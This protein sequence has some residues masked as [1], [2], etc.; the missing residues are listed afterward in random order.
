[1]APQHLET[2]HMET[3]QQTKTCTKCGEEKELTQFYKQKRGK[4]G[5]RP[6]CID[7]HKEYNKKYNKEYN[8]KN[9]EKIKLKTQRWRKANPEKVKEISRKCYYKNPERYKIKAQRWRKANPEKVKESKRK[10]Y[11]EHPEIRK[12]RS[13]KL[14]LMMSDSYIKQRIRNQFSIFEISTNDITPEWINIK[15]RIIQTKR[16]K[17][18]IKTQLS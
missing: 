3:L 14:T 5:V 18:N 16:I 8:V 10:R 4:Y 2:K 7:C 9:S 6:D 15:R 12:E 17:Q 11:T 13:R 1:M